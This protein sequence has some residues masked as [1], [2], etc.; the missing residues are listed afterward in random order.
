M[1][2]GGYNIE[3]GYDFRTAVSNHTPYFAYHHD[4]NIATTSDSQ[5]ILEIPIY[6]KMVHRHLFREQLQRF[7]FDG[8]AINSAIKMIK[9][10]DDGVYLMIGHTKGEHD[11]NKIEEFFKY[12]SQD[13]NVHSMTLQQLV[14]EW[15]G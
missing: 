12:L 10:V 13:K 2:R 15:V 14:L 6:T 5:A 11:F 7:C 4:V 1:W 8:S 3:A 9:D